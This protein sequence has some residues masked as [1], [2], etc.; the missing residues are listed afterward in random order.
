[1]LHLKVCKSDASACQLVV[2]GAEVDILMGMPQ[3]QKVLHWSPKVHFKSLVKLM[4]DADSKFLEDKLSG[5]VS[6]GIID[7][8]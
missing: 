6:T 1:M 2:G 8:H 5:K 7:E 3:K 4:V